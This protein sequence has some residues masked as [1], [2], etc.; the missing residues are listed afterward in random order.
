MSIALA[1]FE[2]LA[3]SAGLGTVWCGMLK[4]ALELA[5]DL[6]PL[7]D[8]P[9]EGVHYYPML[10]GYP[11]VEYARTVQRDGAATIKRLP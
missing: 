10:F 5:P 3:A 6:K 8:L 9:A 11:A 4:M 1:T 7:L 2:L